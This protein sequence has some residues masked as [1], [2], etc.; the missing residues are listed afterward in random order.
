MLRNQI[1]IGA[2]CDAE[3]TASIMMEERAPAVIPARGLDL[4]AL[5]GDAVVQPSG[6]RAAGRDRVPVPARLAGDCR[7][8]RNPADHPAAADDGARSADR[9]IFRLIMKHTIP[10]TYETL[11]AFG[12]SIPLGIALAGL[13]VYSTLAYQALYPNIVFFQLIPKIALAPLFIVWLGIGSPSRVTFS[14]FICSSRSWWPP[15]RDC[16]RSR[17]TCC[18]CAGRCGCRTGR[19]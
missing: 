4:S 5:L 15:R 7:L 9:A 10:T 16:N 12:I 11:L 8:R 6:R 13:M 19:S 14:I 2:P 1:E 3:A 17:R 18:G